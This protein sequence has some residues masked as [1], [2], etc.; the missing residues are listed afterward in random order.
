MNDET[1]KVITAIGS[2]T[3]LESIALLNNINGTVFSL[4]IAAVAG[5]GGFYI[6]KRSS[7]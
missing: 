7:S 3:V 1:I 2:L 6:A 4:V 5:L